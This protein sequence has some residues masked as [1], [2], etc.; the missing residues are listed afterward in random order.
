MNSS[1]P[2]AHWPGGTRGGALSSGASDWASLGEEANERRQG[3][4]RRTF[5][6]CTLVG[7]NRRR[8][9]GRSASEGATQWRTCEYRVKSLEKYKS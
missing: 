1:L 7:N 4:R 6:E 3:N 9:V 5:E 8:I 2:N